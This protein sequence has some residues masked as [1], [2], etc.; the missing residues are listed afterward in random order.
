MIIRLAVFQCGE[1]VV[2]CVSCEDAGIAFRCR[3][4]GSSTNIFGRNEKCAH[5]RS[6][7]IFLW[8]T[9]L[10][11]MLKPFNKNYFIGLTSIGHC[12]FRLVISGCIFLHI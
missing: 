2:G 5:P 1:D 3:F 4:L 7:D 11:E 10:P 12:N 6:L 8:R 9:M